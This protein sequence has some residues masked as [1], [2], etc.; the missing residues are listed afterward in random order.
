MSILNVGSLVATVDNLSE[1]FVSGA[2]I[3]KAVRGGVGEWIAS[4]VG[5][6]GSYR[7]L[8]PAP[9]ADDFARG[10]KTFTG[11]AINSR[12]GEGVT[13][14]ARQ[15]ASSFSDRFDVSG[16]PRSI[17]SVGTPQKRRQASR[18]EHKLAV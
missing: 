3:P 16:S 12:A 10:G 8:L 1:A 2:K 14:G 15:T 11:E 9:T 18:L 7:G 17:T 5:Q 13:D 6:A 4:R